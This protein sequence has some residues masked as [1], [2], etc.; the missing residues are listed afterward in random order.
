MIRDFPGAVDY[1][2]RGLCKWDPANNQII[3]PNNIWIPH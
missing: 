1:I 2:N 3:L